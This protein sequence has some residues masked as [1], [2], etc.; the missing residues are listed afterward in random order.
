MQGDEEEPGAS[1][2]ALVLAEAQAEQP[3]LKDPEGGM[4]QPCTPHG[5]QAR[6]TTV[7]SHLATPV[8]INDTA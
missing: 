1:D 6:G 7:G 5:A 8:A 2:A 3:A 4:T